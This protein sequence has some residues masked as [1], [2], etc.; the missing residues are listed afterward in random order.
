MCVII[1]AP[2]DKDIPMEQIEEAIRNN[3]QGWG[4]LSVHGDGQ[5]DKPVYGWSA[6]AA[7][8][9]WAAGKGGYRIF[10][11]RVSTHGKADL[12]NLHPFLTVAPNGER[13]WLFHNGTVRLP[14]YK[15]DM[16][17]T[18][19]LAQNLRLSDTNDLLIKGL[20]KF[21]ELEASR[22]IFVTAESIW[23]LGNGW[24]E[25]DGVW[26]SNH[27][28][29][30]ARRKDVRSYA[31]HGAW[32]D[33][34]KYR[35]QL[36]PIA[37]ILDNYT[38]PGDAAWAQSP[39]HASHDWH[40]FADGVWRP[41]DIP[42]FNERFEKEWQEFLDSTDSTGSEAEDKREREEVILEVAKRLKDTRDFETVAFRLYEGMWPSTY[43]LV[44][45]K[46]DLKVN[47]KQL[48]AKCLT[49]ADARMLAFK[50]SQTTELEYELIAL[51]L[52]Q[53]HL[54][55]PFTADEMKAIL[56]DSKKKIRAAFR[57]QEKT[58][59]QPPLI[60]AKRLRTCT[61][62]TKVECVVCFPLCTHGKKKEGC[63]YCTAK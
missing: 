56:I 44:E 45:W 29:F 30:E 41:C 47:G 12:A 3:P 2:A 31:A 60:T 40:L 27:T 22:S 59:T 51:A 8:K 19:H 50:P 5:K 20:T 36:S 49:K 13:R 7:K 33:S 39:Y 48:L 54:G 18:W 63:E 4:M 43:D 55:A 52:F 32:H 1:A 11:A 35:V 46:Q 28:A 6:R 42:A 38:K 21:M 14:F 15:P 25:R 61:A 53:E 16:S 10:H 24:V 34:V 58:A 62:H 23:R 26:Y 57:E 17:D 9:A 37:P